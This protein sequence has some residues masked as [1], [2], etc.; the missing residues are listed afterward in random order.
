MSENNNEELIVETVKP[1]GEDNNSEQHTHDTKETVLGTSESIL[2]LLGIAG[3]GFA[4]ALVLFIIL[5]YVI[6]PCNLSLSLGIIEFPIRFPWCEDLSTIETDANPCLEY[7][8]KITGDDYVYE[9]NGEN[10]IVQIEGEYASSPPQGRV[11]LITTHENG[12]FWP[13]E[14]IKLNDNSHWYGNADAF[15]PTQKVSVVFLGDSGK[16]LTDYYDDAAKQAH[17]QNASHEGLRQLT[18][19]IIV[20]DSVFVRLNLEE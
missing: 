5:L 10:Y 15:D 11:R 8:I 9:N 3:I 4:T 6:N 20:C 17:A 19:D 2:T 14:V 7:G 13:N 18:D 12:K 16:V 1:N